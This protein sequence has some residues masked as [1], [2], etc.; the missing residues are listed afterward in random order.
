[1][2]SAS[3]TADPVLVDAAVTCLA[4]CGAVAG[5][6]VG[7]DRGVA[8]VGEDGRCGWLPWLLGD[9]IVAVEVA[10]ATGALAIATVTGEVCL[11]GRHGAVRTIDLG[12]RVRSMAWSDDGALLA[13]CSQA[14][15][16][17][18]VDAAGERRFG[19][20]PS[21]R[22]RRVA[23]QAWHPAAPL[24]VAGAG[25]ASWIDPSSGEVV[26]RDRTPGVVTAVAAD[27]SGPWVALG[28]LRGEVR[29][30]DVRCD[31]ETQVEGWPDPVE[32]LAW[33]PGTG[34]LLVAGGD[35]VT[36][37]AA[38][39]EIED[40]DEGDA[41]A[42]EIGDGAAEIGSGGNHDLR[43][44]TPDLGP[45]RAALDGGRLTALAPHPWRQRA[46]I[47]ADDGRVAV[48]DMSSGRLT[49]LARWSGAVTALRWDSLGDRLFVGTRAGGGWVPGGEE[50]P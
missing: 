20:P 34:R 8:Q 26:R 33:M 41:A 6:V 32:V 27:P 35:E 1:V 16:L 39:H 28:D 43:G 13:A 31:D 47:G 15:G 46:A 24:V 12:S 10:P 40:D 48:W 44:G 2:S 50:A 22:W 25:G 21:R 38:D 49:A 45:P 3:R 36:L 29:L 11:V 23:W 18:V 30:I 5:V 7:T 9:H 14:A 37:W 42:E 17:V 19:L 4:G